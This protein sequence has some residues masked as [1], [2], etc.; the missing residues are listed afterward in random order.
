LASRTPGSW[1]AAPVVAL[2]SEVQD[3]GRQRDAGL[4]DG[5]GNELIDGGAFARG[6]FGLL[7]GGTGEQRRI[8][9][10][11][12]VLTVADCVQNHR[13]IQADGHHHL[14]LERRE[15]SQLRTDRQ[16]GAHRIE[17]GRNDAVTP[18]DG[19]QALG[20]PGCRADR[21]FGVEERQHRGA[22]A[23]ASQ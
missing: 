7:L 19:D 12:V 16:L 13:L 14:G 2:D 5:I 15:R 10:V 21:L 18:G 17:V 8:G 6:A 9:E 3:R 22:G 4:R 1:V 23:D 20:E 11:T